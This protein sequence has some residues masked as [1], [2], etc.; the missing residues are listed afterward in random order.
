MLTIK[1]IS[2]I[3]ACVASSSA[4]TFVVVI[5]KGL[6]YL[7]IYPIHNYVSAFQVKCLQYWPNTGEEQVF[8]DITVT[9]DEEVTYFQYVTRKLTARKV[10]G[11]ISFTSSELA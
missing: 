7:Y 2:T 5:A 9:L 1:K 11:E 10:G 4:C 6:L 8:G 3:I